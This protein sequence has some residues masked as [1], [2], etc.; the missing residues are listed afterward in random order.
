MR[1]EKG[2]KKEGK[3]EIVWNKYLEDYAGFGHIGG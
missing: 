3:R 2:I 1:G